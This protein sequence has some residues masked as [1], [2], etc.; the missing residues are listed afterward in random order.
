MAKVLINRTKEYGETV[1][2]GVDAQTDS[3]RFRARTEKMAM[4]R[5]RLYGYTETEKNY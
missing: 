2:I 3:P 1:F 4:H 5:A